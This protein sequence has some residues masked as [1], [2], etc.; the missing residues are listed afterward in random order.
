MDLNQT[1][2]VDL[3]HPLSPL[4]NC[5]FNTS[6]RFTFYQVSYS[7]I[8]LLGLATNGLALCRLWLSPRTLTSTAVYMAN[9]SAADLFFVVSLPLRI[10][11]HHKAQA[12]SQALPTSWTPG[13]MFYQLTFTLKYQSV[14]RDLLPGLHRNLS[15]QRQRSFILVALGLVQGALLLLFSYCSVLRQPRHRSRSQHRSRQRTLTIIYWVLGVFLLCFVPYH[16]NLLGYTLTHVGLLPSCGLA[17]AC[18]QWCCPWPAPT[19]ASTHL[20]TTSPPA[21]C[22]GSPTAA[23]AAANDEEQC[24]GCPQRD[25]RFYYS[26]IYNLYMQNKVPLTLIISTGFE[27]LNC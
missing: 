9:L 13:G 3:S 5:T 16:L 23:Q 7:V 8:L 4:T 17:R 14:W 11:Y 19:A 25:C 21:W 12:H 20:S 18:T 22:I 1:D 26:T 15:S 27:V 6:Y 2:V 24:W 10:Y